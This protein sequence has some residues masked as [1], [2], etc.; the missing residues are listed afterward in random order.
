MTVWSPEVPT[1]KNSRAPR[2][3]NPRTRLRELVRGVHDGRRR[4]RGGAAL[5]GG[6]DVLVVLLPERPHLRA[7]HQVVDVDRKNTTRSRVPLLRDNRQPLRVP[8]LAAE[9]RGAAGVLRQVRGQRARAGAA[10]LA[11]R[12]RRR[13]RRGGDD[14]GD[15]V[16]I[17]FERVRLFLA[18]EA[19][20]RNA[21][22]CAGDSAGARASR[23]ARCATKDAGRSEARVASN[24]CVA[25]RAAIVSVAR[26]ATKLRELLWA[27]SP[28]IPPNAS[29][30]ANVSVCKETSSV[31]LSAFDQ[32]FK[33]TPSARSDAASATSTA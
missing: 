17:A 13:R 7:D 24:A 2:G 31:S 9:V 32:P 20:A 14:G 18:T 23:R 10:R 28:P 29:A 33:S 5:V 22:M 26:D 27:N 3:R 4:R 16:E 1:P 25:S 19:S 21:A 15:G 8:R 11:Q 6:G 12:R 30:S